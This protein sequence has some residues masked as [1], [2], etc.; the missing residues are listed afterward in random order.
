MNCS[1]RQFEQE[2]KINP[3]NIDTTS[4]ITLD[5]EKGANDL[6]HLIVNAKVPAISKE[7]FDELVANAKVNCPVSKLMNAD[8]TYVAS[9]V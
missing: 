3:E 7:K 8:V 1:T 2:I 9:L 5:R 6:S 4:E